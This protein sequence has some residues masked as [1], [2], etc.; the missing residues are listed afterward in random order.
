[1]KKALKKQ[2]K[3]DELASGYASAGEWLRG[4]ADQVK[5]MAIGAA[6]LAVAV[7]G[8]LYFRG[9]RVQ[10][11]QRAFDEAQAL[12]SGTVGKP[13]DGG[14]A[15]TKEEKFNKALAAFQGVAERYGS[16]ATGRRARYYSALCAIEL[17]EKQKAEGILRDL[18]GRPQAGAVGPELAELALARLETAPGTFD[19]AIARYSRLVDEKATGYPR[20]HVLMNLAVA[21]EQAGRLA[22]AVA[23]FRRVVDEMPSSPFASEARTRADY[24]KLAVAK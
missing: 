2:I 15:A 4:H 11:S 17:G 24:L 23:T 1:V 19:Q 22:E 6:V 20:D 21:Y 18:A 16:L 9:E 8:L 5:T 13:E 12:F 3:Q 10:D 7:G 14:V